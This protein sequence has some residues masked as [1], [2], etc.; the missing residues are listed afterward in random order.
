MRNIL[1]VCAGD[2]ESVRRAAEGGAAR[3]ELCSALSE[4]GITPSEGVVRAALK[5]PG[6]KVNVLIRPRQGDFL[7]SDEEV[8]VMLSDIRRCRGLGVNGVVIG[9]L[10][11][12][13]DVDKEVCGRM[14]EAACGLSITFHRAFDMT[15]DPLQ[16]LEDIIE[17]GCDRILTSGCAPSALDGV[18]MLAELQRR[19]QGRIVILAGGGVSPLNACEIIERSGVRELHASART[20][21]Q[22]GMRHRH[23]G[24]SMGTPGADEYSRLVT[25]TATVARIVAAI[26]PTPDLIEN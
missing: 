3:V 26:A 18:E 17:L 13:G 7:Y 4:G 15:R 5:V 12:D 21:V 23:A 22:S 25:D 16:A 10:T 20:L 1:E 14:I 24:V 9:A 19:A 2:I 11:P 8:E 6:I